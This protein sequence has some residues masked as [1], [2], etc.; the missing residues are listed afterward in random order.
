MV[1][2]S[3]DYIAVF[4]LVLARVGSLMVT[5]PIFGGK[6]VPNQ[7]KAGIAIVLALVFTPLQMKAA[8]AV[9]PG[10]ISYGL[11]AGR[12]ALVGLA[13]G[14]AVGVVFS[15]IQMGSQ[16]VG[17]QIG[18]GLGGVLNP[19]SG[20]ESNVIDSFYGV[21]AT[22]I[23]LAANGHHTV[24]EALSR[25]FQIAPIGQ[26]QAPSISPDQVLAMVQEVIVIALRI[27]MP[28]VAALLLADV[29]LGLLGRAAPQMQV[30]IVGAPVKIAAGLLLL[31]ASTPTTAALMDAVFR[32]LNHSIG[33]LLG[34]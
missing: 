30:M 19:S 23:F 33:T 2:L 32:G 31:A 34:A 22:V 8:P 17:V 21:L 29:V 15:G 16:L 9:P 25:T 3:A 4:G 14:F 11:L 5:A 20:A 6:Q 18:F 1:P 24:L 27:A 7:V 10:L 13:L 12:E 26:A 28:A